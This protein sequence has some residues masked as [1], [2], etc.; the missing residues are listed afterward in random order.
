MGQVSWRAPDELVDRVR[1][2][3]RELG[4]S[5]NQYLTLV[6]EAATNPD[7]AGSQAE[8]VRERLARAKL[9]APAGV[10]RTR[11]SSDELGRVRAAAGR[12][13]TLADLIVENR[14]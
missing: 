2:V 6:V 10:P 13:T 3:A 7:L 8:K 1:A 12:N 14:R 5:V 11:P 9:L 4:Y